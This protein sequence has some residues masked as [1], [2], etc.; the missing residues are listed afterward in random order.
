MKKS[1]PLFYF[2]NEIIFDEVLHI[3]HGFVLVVLLIL[4]FVVVVPYGI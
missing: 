4:Q 3:L 1:L 2:E